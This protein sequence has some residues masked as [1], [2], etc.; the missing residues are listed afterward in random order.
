MVSQLRLQLIAGAIAILVGGCSG[1]STDWNLF[2]TAKTPAPIQPQT[3]NGT[4]MENG[5]TLSVPPI[6]GGQL[7]LKPDESAAQRALELAQKL[8][9]AEEEK[10]SLSVRVHQLEE[11]LDA[12]DKALAKVTREVQ[13]AGDEVKQARE[14]LQQ[15]R[16]Q[17][18]ALREKLKSAEKENLATLRSIVSA[19]EDGLAPGGSPEAQPEQPAS[20]A[21]GQSKSQKN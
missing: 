11:A 16:P 10:R 17:M 20:S 2:G 8:N 14:E 19:L 5:A 13:T 6:T 18:A 1:I 4:K 7:G 12:K 9:S 21:A 3:G 15:W